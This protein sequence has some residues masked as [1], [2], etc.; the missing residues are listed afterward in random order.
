MDT[1]PVLEYSG[2]GMYVMICHTGM[3]IV[4]Y[5]GYPPGTAIHVYVLRSVRTQCTRVIHV[6][7]TRV[8]YYDID[9]ILQ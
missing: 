2:T 6:A 3:A 5:P 1:V 8:Y 4:R 7:A 9:I